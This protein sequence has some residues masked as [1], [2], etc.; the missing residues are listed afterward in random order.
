MDELQLFYIHFIQSSLFSFIQKCVLRYTTDHPTHYTKISQ[1]QQ[2]QKN[3]QKSTNDATST[4]QVNIQKYLQFVHKF[5][6]SK[7]T[8]KKK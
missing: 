3:S 6:F 8:E 1:V 4:W 7:I 5:K 2:L